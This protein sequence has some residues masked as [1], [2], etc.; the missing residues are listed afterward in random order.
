M[1]ALQSSGARVTALAVDLDDNKPIQELHADVRLTP[2][3][4][5]KLAV[6]AGTLR[7]WPASQ[8]F[9]TRLLATAPPSDGVIKGDLIV[10][11]AGDPSLTGQDLWPLAVQLKAAGVTRVTGQLRVRP[12]PFPSVLCET[13]DR[14]KAAT[15]SDDAFDT[16]IASFG[17]DYGTWCIEARARAVGRPAAIT[18]CSVVQLP[19]AIAG[20]VTTSTSSKGDVWAERRTDADGVDRIHVGG[21]MQVGTSQIFYRSMSNPALG[22]GLL[23]H[24][25][26]R[27]IGIEVAGGVSVVDAPLPADAVEL[28]TVYGLA[29]KEQLGRMLRFSNNYIADVLTLTMAAKTERVVPTSLAAAGD[30]LSQ[31]MVQVQRREKHRDATPPLL[32]SGSGLTPENR[33][34]ANDLVD[35]LAY[36]YRD[37]RN[38]GAFYGGLVVPRQAPFAFLRHGSKHWL[39]RVALKTGTMG[40]PHS[41]CGVAGYIRKKDGGWIAFAAIVNGG[42]DH[43]KHV[44]LYKALEAIRAD[45]EQLLTRY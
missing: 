4:L 41:V 16:P 28:A 8:M 27:E 31:F 17:V 30:A 38:F 11:G 23:L 44:P 7:V 6:A 3:S 20:D 42:I 9:E 39:D 14:C 22:A 25:T 40:D 34:S 18:G 37:T 45:I 19:I 26:L 43:N 2:A 33:L 5:T 1:N 29:L 21:T 24:E 35:L 15:A 13:A 32:H 36:E 10:E 12:A